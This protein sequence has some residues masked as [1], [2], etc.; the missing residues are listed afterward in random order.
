[1]TSSQLKQLNQVTPAGT[2]AVDLFVGDTGKRYIIRQIVACN[3]DNTAVKY[4]IF[5]DKDGTTASAATAIRYEKQLFKE[6]DHEI[7]LNI[8]V[9]D[10]AGSLRCQINKASGITFTVYGEELS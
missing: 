6:T 7:N 2:S 3:V 4:S 10:S 1:M 5:H 8:P 9:N